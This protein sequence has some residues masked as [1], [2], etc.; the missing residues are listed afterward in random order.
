MPINRPYCRWENTF[1]ALLECLDAEDDP[2]PGSREDEYRKRVIRLCGQ[3]WR[4]FSDEIKE[5]DARG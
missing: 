4:E 2:H 3:V 1:A 5:E